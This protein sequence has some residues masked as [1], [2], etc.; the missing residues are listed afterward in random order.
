MPDHKISWNIPFH[1]DVYNNSHSRIMDTLWGKE[2]KQIHNL[3]RDFHEIHVRIGVI[4]NAID[5]AL[6]NTRD[7]SKREMELLKRNA[8]IALS[9][10]NNFHKNRDKIYS[11]SFYKNDIYTF[12]TLF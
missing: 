9:K 4:A 11:D 2:P 6:D 3:Y 10:M 8:M 12:L 1:S 5:S 7:I